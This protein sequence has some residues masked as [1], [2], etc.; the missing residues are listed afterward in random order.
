LTSSNKRDNGVDPSNG[1]PLEGYYT[2]APALTSTHKPL[3]TPRSIRLVK[4]DIFTPKPGFSMADGWTFD[5]VDIITSNEK[6]EGVEKIFLLLRVETFELD[7][8]PPYLAL[9]YTWGDPIRRDLNGGGEDASRQ[10][11]PDD[12]I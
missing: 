12:K 4:L 10:P 11:H 6:L 5:Q 9:S 2:D 8:C 1:P 3:K 7:S